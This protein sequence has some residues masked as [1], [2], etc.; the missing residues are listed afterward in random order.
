MACK[1]L[2]WEKQVKKSLGM[3]FVWL[4]GTALVFALNVGMATAEEAVVDSATP[5]TSCF[6]AP[7]K[8]PAAEVDA[9]L[10][11][12]GKLIVDMASGGLPLANRAR[13][14]G[15]SSNKAVSALINL[16]KTANDN[17]KAAIGAGLARVVQAC[18]GT[19]DYAANIQKLVAELGDAAMITAFMAA[20]G[21]VQ[22]AA[23]A[24]V[25]NSVGGGA[26][27]EI[28]DRG[29]DNS[30]TFGGNETV[31]TSTPDYDIGDAGASVTDIVSGVRR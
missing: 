28:G 31:P 19:P 25:S 10:A 16:A 29:A 8:L 27:N 4:A 5:D 30:V 21:D 20:S 23:L 14:L 9:F 15:G 1:E 3:S 12:P 11:N 22:V 6:V 13:E 17:Q 7:A 24:G 26:V 18:A 2:S